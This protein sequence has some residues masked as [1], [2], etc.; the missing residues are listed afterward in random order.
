MHFSEAEERRLA[1]QRGD[2]LICEGG[3]IGRTAIWN[4]ELTRCYYQ[5]HLH[6]IRL[7]NDR[8]EPLF[9]LFWLW[10]AFEFGKVYFGR[11]NVTTIPN[12]SQS[13]LAELPL[14]VPPSLRAAQNRGC[15]VAG[16]AG[17]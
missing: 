8:A 10:Y 4:G 2:L 12:L 9:I 1:L 6:R 17:D 11:G 15:V 5:N 7:K 13:K 16:A 3:D 14:P